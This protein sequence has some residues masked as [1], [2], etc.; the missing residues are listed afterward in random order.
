MKSQI[1]NKSQLPKPQTA[2]ALRFDYLVIRICNL[3]E[4][5]L[6]GLVICN[7][8]LVWDFGFVFCNF[9]KF[10]GSSVFS[11]AKNLFSLCG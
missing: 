6:W 3:F 5:C 11:V 8:M 9:K 10:S 1:T 2:V 4:I 7:L